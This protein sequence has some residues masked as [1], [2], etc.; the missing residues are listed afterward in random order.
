MLAMA[1]AM[2]RSPR[3]ICIDEPSMGLSPRYVDTVYAAL[4][5]L[6]E[7]RLTMLVVEQNANR[8]LEIADRAYILRGGQIV[9]EGPAQELRRDPKVRKAYLGE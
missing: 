9:R 1:R 3:L 4:R 5:R 6:K 7:R 8:A 2:M